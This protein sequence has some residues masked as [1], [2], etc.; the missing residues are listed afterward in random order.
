MKR[1]NKGTQLDQL[2]EDITG[3]HAKKMN[4]ILEVLDEE[5]FVV[6]YLKLLEFAAPKLQR[7][8]FNANIEIDTITVE[9]VSV[10]KDSIEPT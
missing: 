9:H 7:T 3:R 4:A 1:L 8:E 5:D 10:G 2:L 6:S